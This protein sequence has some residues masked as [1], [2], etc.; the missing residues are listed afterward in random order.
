LL[1]KEREQHRRIVFI[2]T[3]FLAVFWLL[4]AL[5]HER[6]ARSVSALEIVPEIATWALPALAL[7]L[8]HR[9]V[10]D[11]YYGRTQRF[12]E[13][14]P[15]RRGE[16]VAV[17]L[18]YG[19]ACL[20]GWALLTLAGALALVVGHQPLDGHF[21]L[22]LAV[23][24]GVFVL[25]LWAVVF[26][27]CCFG[28]LRLPLFAVAVLL[29]V[30]IG[31]R[32]E[33]SLSTAGPLAL[34]DPRTY[35]V[36]RSVWPLGALAWSLGLAAAALAAVFTLVRLRDGSILES[37]ARPLNL[38]EK[39]AIATL[40]MGGFIAWT[41]LESR[42][43]THLPAL[44][45]DKVLR[46]PGLEVAYF[47]DELRP[48]AARLHALVL[49]ALA[50]LRP[51]LPDGGDVQ[52]RPGHLF[53]LRLVHAAELLPARPQVAAYDRDEGLVVRANFLAFLGADPVQT[54]T[55]LAA[56]LHFV[57]NAICGETVAIESRH[58]LLDGFTLL[59]AQR[60]LA[61]PRDLI[62]DVALAT[63]A[64]LGTPLPAARDLD[65]YFSLAERAGELPAAAVAA[66]GWRFLEQSAGAA[67][68]FALA[69][70]TFAHRSKGDGRDT[71]FRWRWSVDRLLR[72][73][74]G[75]RLPEFLAAWQ[76]WLSHEAARPERAR[77]LAEVPRAT[78]AY[79][80][81]PQDLDPIVV[82]GEVSRV[83]PESDCVVVHAREGAYDS[84]PD[85]DLFNEDKVAL[86][87]RGAGATFVQPLEGDYES[88]ERAF[89]ALEC[90]TP[91]TTWGVRLAAG[92][93]TVP[94]EPKGQ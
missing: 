32:S 61:P 21:I 60:A 7:L 41:T 46:G 69:R 34:I 23:R 13:A 83:G 4:A 28:R 71:L 58:W 14:L 75:K 48:A 57:A 18:T 38:R 73:A 17:K 94:T 37:L 65:A 49:P 30:V 62:V 86:V 85:P 93:V 74:T 59:L 33:T 81:S 91:A 53:G 87:A 78:I 70:L 20:W 76:A 22:L 2:L 51:V 12:L 35:V 50:E 15:I 39:A 45:T 47:S 8:G 42:K 79:G 43:P 66:S 52:G 5:I 36:E 64:A 56:V 26:L 16:E 25:V 11:E 40:L 29:I 84:V 55:A 54:Q 92:R 88:G 77:L 9:I 80:F 19:L 31:N 44:S 3:A 1:A 27:F 6:A 67:Q 90:R 89:V 72:T 68:V 10:I 82:R 63:A 24:L